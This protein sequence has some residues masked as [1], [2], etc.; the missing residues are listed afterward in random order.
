MIFC[1]QGAYPA[2]VRDWAKHVVGEI[3]WSRLLFGSEYPVCVWRDETFADV[4]GWID[5]AGLSPNEA[6]RRA[7]FHDN[8]ASALFAP[9]QMPVLL[10]SRW[11]R[12]DLKRSAP[13]WYFPQRTLDVDEQTNRLLIA[14]WHR[15]GPVIRFSDFVAQ[16][17]RDAAGKL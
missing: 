11:H 16:T 3:G 13:V 4:I 7:F 5:R 10:D 17:L 12:M 9:R 15:S 8:A 6:E 1:R 2:A 14:A